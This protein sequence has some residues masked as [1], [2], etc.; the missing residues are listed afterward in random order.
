MTIRNMTEKDIPK[1]AAVDAKAFNKPWG[2][3]SFADEI[4]KDYAHYFVCEDE[5][6]IIG[7]VGIWCLYETAELIRI[8]VNP[9]RQQNGVG[10]ILMTEILNCARDCGCER[11]L[12][13]V[14]AENT[15]AQSLYS[16]FGFSE[17]SVR[18]GYYD[19]ADARIMEKKLV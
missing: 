19:G 11:M 7:Y 17:I 18:K 14:H 4:K 8:A 12:L 6:E 9:S 13:E 2:S 1:A 10:S 5:T 3:M 16:K 15:P